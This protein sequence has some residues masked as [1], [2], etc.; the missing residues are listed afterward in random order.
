MLG[1][2]SPP[3]TSKETVVSNTDMHHGTCLT[4]GAW[5]MSGSLTTA[6]GK[7]FP[8]FPA[9]VQPTILLIWQEAHWW[10][11]FT[12]FLLN[13]LWS[14]II[15]NKQVTCQISLFVWGKT[16]RR[17]I[18]CEIHWKCGTCNGQPY[19][20]M[21]PS[22]LYLFDLCPFCWLKLKENDDPQHI[23]SS[24]SQIV[25]AR[26]RQIYL[27]TFLSKSCIASVIMD[28]RKVHSSSV[29]IGFIVHNKPKAF[30]ISYSLYVVL[31]M[32]VSMPLLIYF[33]SILTDEFIMHW[34]ISLWWHCLWEILTKYC[35]P[36]LSF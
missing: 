11:T 35:C 7:T 33:D 6:T 8:A 30:P 28:Q 18:I 34:Q 22:F 20:H 24:R 5:W 9:H 25:C 26:W 16:I 4:H 17:I 10:M 1:T 15:K 27:Y 12:S 29:V 23:L 19:F 21:K 3:P 13:C 36:C 32:G 14:D 31:T 2:F